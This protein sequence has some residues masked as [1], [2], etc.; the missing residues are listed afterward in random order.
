[1]CPPQVSSAKK[2]K[3][4]IASYFLR[5]KRDPPSTQAEDPQQETKAEQKA[6]SQA[7]YAVH[8]PGR[9]SHE[10]LRRRS[11]RE[12][13]REKEKTCGSSQTAA[14]S[15]EYDNNASDRRYVRCRNSLGKNKKVQKVLD[16]AEQP[17]LGEGY[18]K[19]G[20]RF[21]GKERLTPADDLKD[22]R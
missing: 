11:K 12:S 14:K 17:V 13:R 3:R 2:P 6:A 21:V 18:N 16:E 19:Y 7:K 9:S 1:M 5:S 10:I 20:R 15:T 22:L 4:T 8:T